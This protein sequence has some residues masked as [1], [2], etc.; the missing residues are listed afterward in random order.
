MTVRFHFLAHRLSSATSRQKVGV[1]GAPRVL[2]KKMPRSGALSDRRGV[3]MFARGMEP[4]KEHVFSKETMVCLQKGRMHMLHVRQGGFASVESAPTWLGDM[5]KPDVVSKD[6]LTLLAHSGCTRPDLYVMVHLDF[7]ASWAGWMEL[8]GHFVLQTEYTSL[9]EEIACRL[10][11]IVLQNMDVETK[12]DEDKKIELKSREFKLGNAS[13][14]RYNCLSDSLCQVLQ[15]A[16]FIEA[17]ELESSLA[18]QKFC[19]SYR[20]YVCGVEDEALRPRQRDGLGRALP[21]SEEEHARAFL[22]HRVH[23]APFV[24]YCVSMLGATTMPGKLL[25]EVHSR[26]DSAF[27]P[28]DIMCVWEGDVDQG[29]VEGRIHVYNNTGDGWTGLHYEPMC[30]GF[31][32]GRPQGEVR[33]S[34]KTSS[35]IRSQKKT[36][37]S[38]SH[39]T[40]AAE[41]KSQRKAAQRKKRRGSNLIE[42]EAEVGAE[43]EIAREGSE[44]MS[45][46]KGS[47]ATATR[48]GER[49]VERGADDKEENGDVTG[50]ETGTGEDDQKSENIANDGPNM[51]AK[52]DEEVPETF[53]YTSLMPEGLSR[54]PRA[55]KEAL[56]AELGMKLRDNPTVPA[57]H[58]NDDGGW[59]AALSQSTAPSLPP[60]H[61]AF[62]GCIWTGKTDDDLEKHLCNVHGEV[63]A[64]IV[65][66]YQGRGGTG[67]GSS[68]WAAYTA[69]LTWKVRRG[70]PTASYAIDR[71][72]WASFSKEIGGPELEELCCCVCARLFP[73]CPGIPRSEIEW[74]RAVD[75]AEGESLFLGL[76]HD[77]ASNLLGVEQYMSQYGGS[78]EHPPN[79]REHE[80][81]F[82]D[83]KAYVSLGRE[84]PL[85]VLCCP[86]DRRCK[87]C[88]EVEKQAPV[89]CEEC[90][91][92]VCSECARS[93]R[94]KRLPEQA[95]AND[96]LLFY[97]PRMLYDRKV[98]VVEMLCAST[99]ITSMI[100]FTL[101]LRQEALHLSEAYMQTERIAARGNA[102][103]FPLPWEALL[104]ELVRMEKSDRGE[105]PLLPRIGR[106]LEHLVKRGC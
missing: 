92:P 60:K 4:A 82:E 67:K 13:T 33:N 28:G 34:E 25:L 30:M 81:E 8:Q 36:K 76:N 70:A 22:E 19:Q 31:R 83:W 40:R 16:G 9:V 97:A 94:E 63:L 75:S 11:T 41:R 100:C 53:F 91:V 65:A 44:C 6:V 18:R 46:H 5:D 102:T 47:N 87:H 64:P 58:R 50:D 43:G 79:L 23:A 49:K 95:L 2:L 61:C 39:G 78:P 52:E 88:P 27:L 106:D 90:E 56:V 38:G 89:L 48:E 29:Q 72:A 68:T 86:E 96:M 62:R 80:D 98:T 99:C 12:S 10:C 14:F 73:R 21:V 37:A 93:L 84:K 7:V 42:E 54:D 17:P 71:R 101:E 103:S 45:E 66:F 55:R 1:L 85:E 32:G 69:G 15:D 35:S 104:Q 59:D 77:E 51:E 3:I 105:R 24:E 57:L 20:T 26:F 74:H